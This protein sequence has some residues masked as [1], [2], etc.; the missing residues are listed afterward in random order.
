VDP[1]SDSST[2]TESIVSSHAANERRENGAFRL[3][4]SPLPERPIETYQ[5]CQQL[6]S[7]STP[8]R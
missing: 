7:S 8:R 6:S 5:Q 2:L 3:A 1:G 4:H